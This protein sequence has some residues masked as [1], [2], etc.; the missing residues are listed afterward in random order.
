MTSPQSQQD[1]LVEEAGAA[2]STYKKRKKKHTCRSWSIPPRNLTSFC[3]LVSRFKYMKINET[4][5]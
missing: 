5:S 2:P 3:R 1:W 4:D